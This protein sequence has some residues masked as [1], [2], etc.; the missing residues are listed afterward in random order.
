MTS[1]MY[2]PVVEGS[3]KEEP[4]YYPWAYACAAELLEESSWKPSSAL[5]C[6]RRTDFRKR[7]SC[8]DESDEIS[9]LGPKVRFRD[10]LKAVRRVSDTPLKAL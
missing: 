3:T 6:T 5:A 2:C 10:L 4:L 9:A 8:R 7:A 1:V